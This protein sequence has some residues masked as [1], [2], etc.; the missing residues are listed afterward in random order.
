ML[1]GEWRISTTNPAGSRY[2]LGV[3]ALSHCGHRSGSEWLSPVVPHSRQCQ[4]WR[5]ACT[6]LTLST[7]GGMCQLRLGT[8]SPAGIADSQVLAAGILPPI[9][10]VG[11]LSQGLPETHPR[12]GPRLYVGRELRPAM[13]SMIEPRRLS[14]RSITVSSQQ[15]PTRCPELAVSDPARGVCR[16]LPRRGTIR[17]TTGR[18]STPTTRRAGQTSPF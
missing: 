14:W 15:S 7:L 18:E 10:G 12:T 5:S 1:C 2:F 9:A 6:S 11:A 4:R 16:S 13:Q 17:R 3:I 8:R